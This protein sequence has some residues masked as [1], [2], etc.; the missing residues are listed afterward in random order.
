M[1]PSEATAGKTP[2]PA[3]KNSGHVHFLSGEDAA[4]PADRP[5]NGHNDLSR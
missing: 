4:G 2:T 1:L 3:A 5:T